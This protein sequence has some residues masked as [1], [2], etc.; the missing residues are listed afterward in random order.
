M[1]GWTGISLVVNSIILSGVE[2]S[3]SEG[4]GMDGVVTLLIVNLA[5]GYKRIL[6]INMAA[7]TGQKGCQ[8]SRTR[9]LNLLPSS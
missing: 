5:R 1:Q 3:R 8:A 9:D 4:G 6:L 2:S 7:L